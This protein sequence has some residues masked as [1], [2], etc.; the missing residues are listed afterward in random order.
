MDKIYE[1]LAQEKRDIFWRK[2]EGEE[3]FPTDFKTI[4]T[5]TRHKLTNRTK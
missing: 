3:T 4:V 1:G 2:E 5:N